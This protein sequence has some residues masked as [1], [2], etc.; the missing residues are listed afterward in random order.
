[1]TLEQSGGIRSTAYEPSMECR[2]G[3]GS[4]DGAKQ[5]FRAS[6]KRKRLGSLGEEVLQ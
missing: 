5:E 4:F 2:T 6:Y 1:M 3:A